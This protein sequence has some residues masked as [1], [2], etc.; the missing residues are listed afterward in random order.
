[1]Q[2]SCRDH[3]IIKLTKITI[4]YRKWAY[5]TDRHN[6]IIGIS[7]LQEGW[8]WHC[9]SHPDKL[10]LNVFHWQWQTFQ[11]QAHS[12]KVKNA[13]N[14]LRIIKDN[15]FNV[16]VACSSSKVMDAYKDTNYNA[17][18]YGRGRGWLYPFSKILASTKAENW[19]RQSLQHPGYIF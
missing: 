11:G 2:H 18:L 1:M 12:T 15:C 5:T 16:K 3:Y 8:R 13:Y 4:K 10:C 7:L 17:Q 19:F 6:L 9:Y 14:K